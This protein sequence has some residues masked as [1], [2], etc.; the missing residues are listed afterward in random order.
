MHRFFI[1]PE[2][3]KEM[4]VYLSLP[5]ELAHQ[6]RDVLRLNLG[7]RLLLLDNQGNE[8]LTAVESSS[9]AGVIV[10]LLERHAGKAAAPMRIILCPGLM[11]A[12][13]FEWILE[14]GTEL[15]V[16]AFAPVLY[17]RSTAGLQDTGSAKTRRWQRIL[18][19]AS[20]QCG[21][22]T[23][24]ELHPARPLAQALGSIPSGALAIMP[25]EEA[26]GQ[27]L[28]DV[29]AGVRTR[30]AG[31]VIPQTVL[32]FIGPE[33]GLTPEETALARRQGVQI[34]TLGAHILRAETAALACVANVIYALEP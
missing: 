29:L 9:R 21:R 30:V 3:V 26:E 8:I 15:G 28:R 32:L 4:G 27:T 7:E 17:Q 18:Q 14:K 1:A 2:L 20:E 22:C 24:P 11:K 16:A 10:Q 31:V 6:V 5:R 13:R 19:E 23:L 12:A 34:V 25:W 33:G